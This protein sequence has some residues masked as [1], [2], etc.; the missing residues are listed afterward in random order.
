LREPHRNPNGPTMTMTDQ[1]ADL[2]DPN[3]DPKLSG[4]RPH[5]AS[6]RNVEF[7][8]IEVVVQEGNVNRAL[9]M[10]KRKMAAEG[11]YKELRKRRFFEKPSEEKKRRSREAERRRKKAVRIARERV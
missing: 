3:R 9:S 1:N 2:L 11:V 6:A 4:P 10:L 7:R 8:P 5:R